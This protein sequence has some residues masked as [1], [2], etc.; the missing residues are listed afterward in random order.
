MATTAQEI[1]ETAIPHALED[2]GLTLVHKGKVRN[3]YTL[4]DHDDLLLVMATDRVSIFD[5][6]LPASIRGKGEV[7]TA[8]TIFW[9]THVLPNSIPHHLIAYGQAIDE[10]LPSTLRQSG[11]LRKRCIVVKKFEMLPVEC[12]VRGYLT[13]S[14]WANYQVHQH[15]CGVR[16]PDGLHDGSQLPEPIFTPTTKAVKGHD[17]NLCAIDV[18][19]EHGEW[20][21]TQS[22]AAFQAI[23][24]FAQRRGVILADTKFEFA[25][26]G[27][28]ADEVGTP[29]SSGF[30]DRTRW[31]I[32]NDNGISL[33][34]YDKQHLRNW[35]KGFGVQKLDPRNPDDQAYV[36]KLFV[37]PLVLQETADKYHT[38][39]DRLIG[40]SLQEF[41]RDWMG[42]Y[43]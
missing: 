26:N 40:V 1:L 13:G 23:S 16:L 41:H 33:S 35:G 7:L 2:A 37:P 39:F 9:L 36:A 22:L 34:S 32:A 30:W 43:T 19:A 11:A 21:K 31:L 15:V 38:I 10:Y 25:K 28:L 5:F 29:D 24:T 12:I 18:I 42:I 8:M 3:T 14:G 17:E 27:A 6:V 20:L 4:P